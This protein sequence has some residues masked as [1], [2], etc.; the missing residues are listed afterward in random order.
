MFTRWVD[1]VAAGASNY[2][3]DPAK[4]DRADMVNAEIGTVLHAVLE[5]GAPRGS[6]LDRLARA[7]FS[8]PEIA[9][10]LNC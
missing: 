10:T 5:D 7:P 3:R 2:E 9:S 8:F 1:G 6:L 4:Q